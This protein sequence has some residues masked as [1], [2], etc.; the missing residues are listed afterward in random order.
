MGDISL[1]ARVQ[2]VVFFRRGGSIVNLLTVANDVQEL[3]TRAPLR[4]IR[5]FFPPPP[6]PPSRNVFFPQDFFSRRFGESVFFI[7]R[8]CFGTFVVEIGILDCLFPITS[9]SFDPCPQSSHL[10]LLL[11]AAAV[12]VYRIV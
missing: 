2:I 12:F 5:D 4:C 11:I 7:F 10:S 9:T 1:C 8:P 6:P 3:I